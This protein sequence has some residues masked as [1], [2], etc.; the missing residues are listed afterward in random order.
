MESTIY[1]N[2]GEHA[3]DCS[4]EEKLLSPVPLCIIDTGNCVP[5]KRE[6]NDGPHTRGR[7]LIIY[8]CLY[9]YFVVKELYTNL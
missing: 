3:C 8:S 6:N 1:S 7:N 2:R 5:G 9:L 4:T